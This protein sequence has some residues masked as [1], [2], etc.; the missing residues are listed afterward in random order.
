MIDGSEA[1]QEFLKDR[2]SELDEAE[3]T[4]P[5]TFDDLVDTKT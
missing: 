3:T 4:L 5:P 1:T 2:Y